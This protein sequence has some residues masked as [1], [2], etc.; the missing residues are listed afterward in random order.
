MGGYPVNGRPLSEM[1]CWQY[2]E[3]WQQAG[4]ARALVLN[5]WSVGWSVY[6]LEGDG[7]V[8]DLGQPFLNRRAALWA[9]VQVLREVQPQ[10]FRTPQVSA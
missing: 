4:P 3:L 9:A 8:V 6:L 7:S 5:R 1:A 10:W 2:L